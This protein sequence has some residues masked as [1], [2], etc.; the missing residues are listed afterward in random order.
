MARAAAT[1]VDRDNADL[2]RRARRKLEVRTRILEAAEA[3]FDGHG[4]GTTTVA[5]IC[6]RADVAQKTFFNHFVTRQDLLR[7]LASHAIDR[8]LADVE[9]ARRRAGTTRARLIAFF[10]CIADNVEAAGPMHRDLVAEI[11]QVGHAEPNRPA[12]ARALH[13]AFGALVADGLAAGEL[14]RAH[15]AETST[16]MILGAFYV[17]MFNWAYLEG[18]PLRRQ[19]RRAARFLGDALTAS[20]ARRRR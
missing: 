2:G 11:I 18:Y 7:A 9:Q 14:S 8:L 6:E 10:D 12:Q 19:A 1:A 15:S 13:A 16:E 5:D 3:L 20:P 17:L 4:V